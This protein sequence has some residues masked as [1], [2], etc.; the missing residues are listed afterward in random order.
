M[1]AVLNQRSLVAQDNLVEFNITCI[2]HPPS[3]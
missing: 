3:G 1:R 2:T